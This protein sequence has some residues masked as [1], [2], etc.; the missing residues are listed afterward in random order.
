VTPT[1]SNNCLTPQVFPRT[2][3]NRPGLPRIAFR[4]GTYADF[5]QALFGELDRTPLLLPWSHRQPDDPGIALLEGVAIIGDILTFYTELYANEAWLRTATWPESV[6]AL[7]RLLGYRPAPG[8]GGESAAAFEFKGASAVTV[9]AGFGF[10]ARITGMP[11]PVDFETSGALVASPQLNRFSLY[12]PWIKPAIDTGT[13][14]LAVATSVLAAAGVTIKAKDRLA[15]VDPATVNDPNSVNWQIAVVSSVSTLVD[16]TVITLTG[17]WQGS[18]PYGRVLMAYKLGRSFHAFG[19]NAP[20]NQISIKGTTA[21]TTKVDTSIDVSAILGAFPLERKVDDLSPGATML[22]NLEITFPTPIYEEALSFPVLTLS[23]LG[24]I[25]EAQIPTF[26]FLLPATISRAFLGSDKVGPI[27][28]SVTMVE[29]SSTAYDGMA[30]RRTA[31]CL[32]VIGSGFQVEGQRF[33]NPGGI[34]VDHLLYY[35]DGATYQQLNGRTLQ[36]VILNPDDSVARLEQTT[37]TIDPSFQPG[38][39]AVEF[40]TLYMNPALQQFSWSDFPLSAPTVTVFGNVVAITQGKT[41]PQATLGNG[42]ARQVNQTFLIPKGPLTWLGDE[43]LT[44]PRKPELQVLVNN[45]EWNEVDSLFGAGPADTSYIIRLDDSGNSWIQFGDGINGARLP[46]GV[47]NVL[48]TNRTGV[49]ANGDRTP[50]TNPSPASQAQNL[51]AIRFYETVT[52][53]AAP[54]SSDSARQAAPGRVQSLGRLVSLSDFEY[55]ALALPG[56]E[57]AQATWDLSNGVPLLV[58]TVL[59]ANPSQAATDKVQTSMSLANSTRGPQRFQVQVQPANLLYVYLNLTFGLTKGYQQNDVIAAIETA[60]GVIPAGGTA[61]AGGLFSLDQRQLG[62]PEYASRI[63]GVV[64][65]V[66]GVDWVEVTALDQLGPAG[67]P[68]TLVVPATTVR[69]DQ[70]PCASNQ[71]LALYAAQFNPSA[72]TGAA[73]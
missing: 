67:D 59:L 46:S 38:D 73:V 1:C 68:S 69:V 57:K 23:K 52:G 70:V 66:K 51:T 44:P 12:A 50:G 18:V 7:V 14:V 31:Q 61:P 27:S 63:E 5:R 58:L 54:E 3:N 22:V 13:S 45:I 56:V 47:G 35:G 24:Q 10:N 8:I 60:L 65:N 11:Q 21:T 2:I 72:S 15:L 41:Q 16:Q 6:T 25:V 62:G 29:F 34:G 40:R 49:G 30:D 17:S 36:F 42:D 33:L 9:P 39:V 26:E 43:A 37:A 71:V 53:G 32:E 55:E 4:I 64:Q 48:I 19:Y 20:T 28:G